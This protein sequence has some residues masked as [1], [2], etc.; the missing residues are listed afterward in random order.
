MQDAA[1]AWV[2]HRDKAHHHVHVAALKYDTHS[3]EY[4]GPPGRDFLILDRAMREIEL[5]QGWKH[6]PGPHM[7]QNCHVVKAP[8]KTESSSLSARG[9]RRTGKRPALAGVD[10][11]H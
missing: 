6:S 4:L 9:E 5:A 3:L 8:K 11:M 2:V 7:A 1:A 10:L